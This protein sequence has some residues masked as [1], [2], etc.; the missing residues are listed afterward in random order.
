MAISGG[1]CVLHPGTVHS[2]T[3]QLASSGSVRLVTPGASTLSLTSSVNTKIH[4]VPPQ[5]N[6]HSHRLSTLS[7]TIGLLTL[8]HCCHENIQTQWPRSLCL[9]A[10]NLYYHQRRMSTGIWDHTVTQNL[11]QPALCR[12]THIH[13]YLGCASWFSGQPSR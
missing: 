2:P 12:H 8:Q 9:S 1:P 13:R 5:S 10:M 4:R 3:A 6:L 7:K 11:S